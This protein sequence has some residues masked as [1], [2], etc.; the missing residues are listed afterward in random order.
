MSHTSEDPW[1]QDPSGQQKQTSSTTIH[2][3]V[4]GSSVNELDEAGK[5]GALYA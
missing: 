5:V 2:R 3:D 4:E 1:T